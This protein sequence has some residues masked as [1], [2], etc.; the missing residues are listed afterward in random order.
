[1]YKSSS[2][3]NFTSVDEDPDT[4]LSIASLM[5]SKFRIT[6]TER[7]SLGEQR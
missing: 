2:W 4:N 1:M 5:K 3:S 6:D 7:G